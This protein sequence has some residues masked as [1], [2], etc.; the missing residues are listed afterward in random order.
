V[1]EG[2][3]PPYARIAAE[4]R[5]RISRGELAP[6]DRLPSTREIVRT[7]GVAIATATR[8]LAV[9]RDEGLARP[10]RG[11][12]TVVGGPVPRAGGPPRRSPARRSPARPAPGVL[13]RDRIV[14]AAIAVADA[15]GLDAVSMRRVATQLGAAPMSLYRHVA[16]KDDLLLQ[17]MDAVFRAAWHPPARPPAG[18]RPRLELAHR[19]LWT[20]FKRHPWLATAMSVTRPPAIPAGLE[21]AE[22][23]LAALAGSGLDPRAALDVHVTLFTFVRGTAIDLEPERAAEA[24]TGLSSEDWLDAQAGAVAGIVG[25]GRFPHFARLADLGYDLDLDSIFEHGLG[26]LLDGLA[27]SLDP[28]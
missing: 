12:G 13:S 16:T 25:S 22:W 2:D 9:L 8:A 27:A 17:M 19:A 5:G 15:E 24:A 3:T 14:A 11:V 26:W 7:H 10:V 4:L 1:N 20:V 23:V 6:G 28:S 18:W 21:F